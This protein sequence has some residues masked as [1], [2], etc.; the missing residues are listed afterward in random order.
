MLLLYRLVCEDIHQSFIELMR[1]DLLDEGASRLLM[2]DI[3]SEGS[4]D[5][6]HYAR[7]I[8]IVLMLHQQLH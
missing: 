3:R 1:I 2:T 5:L 7:A 4:Q 6:L 8:R